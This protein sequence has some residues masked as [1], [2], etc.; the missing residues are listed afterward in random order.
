MLDS[1]TL[2]L[3]G[4]FWARISLWVAGLNI[5]KST[6]FVS[7]IVHKNVIQPISVTFDNEKN[8]APTLLFTMQ[9]RVSKQRDVVLSVSKS[10]FKY[11]DD[12]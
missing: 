12:D 5:L 8:G 3:P 6:I 2:F 7:L 10:Y 9:H 4:G 1:L 11:S